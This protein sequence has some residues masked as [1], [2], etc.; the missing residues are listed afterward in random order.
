MERKQNNV[1]NNS[2]AA[3][4]HP[5]PKIPRDENKSWVFLGWFSGRA[6]GLGFD[7][8]CRKNTSGK[9]NYAKEAKNIE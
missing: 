2:T 5:P 7:G 4:P 6:Q 8:W 3:H 1:I 9:K